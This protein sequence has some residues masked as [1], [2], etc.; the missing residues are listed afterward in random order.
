MGRG[1]LTWIGCCSSLFFHTDA[2][3]LA[4][5]L[6]SVL[7]VIIGLCFVWGATDVSVMPS[8]IGYWLM[9]SLS[10]RIPLACTTSTIRTS[11]IT[12][13]N[14]FLNFI[15]Y[16]SSSSCSH[17]NSCGTTGWVPVLVEES[18]Q[19]RY[20]SESILLFTPLSRGGSYRRNLNIILFLSFVP[21]NS[22]RHSFPSFPLFMVGFRSVFRDDSITRGYDQPCYIRMVVNNRTSIVFVDSVGVGVAVREDGM[23]EEGET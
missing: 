9:S 17:W 3:F 23:D 20:H 16:N 10:R 18:C 22:N 14:S 8:R 1:D 7:A 21:G 2:A 5:W 11:I 19:A 13:S 6:W 12:I 15:T 4:L